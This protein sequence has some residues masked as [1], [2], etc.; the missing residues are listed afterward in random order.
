MISR[1]PSWVWFGAWSLSFIAGIVNVVGL[2]GFEHQAVTHLTG[3]TSMLAAALGK[4]NLADALH[5]AAVIGSFV[6]G[7]ALSGF[8][9]KDSTLKLGRSYGVALFLES[10]LLF[11]AVPFMNRHSMFGIYAAACAC[12]LQ[13]AM[14]STYSGTVV[15]TT[16]VSGMFTD[17]GISLG[18]GL[19]G[20][21]I[22]RKR[23]RLS[24][25]VI[26]G[27]L[28]GGIAGSVMFGF[29][30]CSALYLP[31]GLTAT[32]SISYTIYMTRTSGN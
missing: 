6:S 29:A 15:R 18:H 1:L 16:H 20:M 10:L 19:R 24:F 22:D 26:S 3:N 9:V 17:L 31:A 23:T 27:F 21:P 4:H 14:A 12:G 5:F 25:L 7:A 28:C 32:A 13:N 11:I 8:I 30:G 2:M